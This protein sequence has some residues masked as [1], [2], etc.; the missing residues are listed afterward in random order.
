V[1]IEL[2]NRVAGVAYSTRLSLI[3]RSHDS[4]TNY[5]VPQTPASDHFAA[6]YTEG[7]SLELVHGFKSSVF[8]ALDSKPP[9]N[10]V[11]SFLQ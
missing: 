11:T 7:S 1:H 4:K 9:A 10:N 5:S 2:V 3:H 8:S 6:N